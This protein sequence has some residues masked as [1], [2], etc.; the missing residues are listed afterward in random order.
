VRRRARNSSK[1][2]DG[3]KKARNERNSKKNYAKSDEKTLK[4]PS[5]K[6]LLLP[7]SPP[8]HYEKL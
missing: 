1:E 5:L 6:F 4:S 8:S 7:S 3:V 2:V